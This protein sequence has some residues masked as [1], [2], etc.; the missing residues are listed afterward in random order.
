M[1]KNTA[2]AE[3]LITMNGKAAENALAAL[4]KQQDQ[5]N[6]AVKAG[7]EAQKELDKLRNTSIGEYQKVEGR[8]YVQ[9]MKHLEDIIKKGKENQRTLNRLNKEINVTELATKKY[10]EVLK[11][12]NGSSL[13]ELQAVA[14]QLKFE[15]RQLPPDTQKFIDK[16]KQ[17]KEVNTRINQLTTSFKGLVDQGGFLKRLAGNLSNYFGAIMIGYQSVKRLAQGFM[18]LYKTISNF[19]QANANLASILGATSDQMEKMEKAAIALGSSSRYTAT[20]V[21]ELQT[22]L[23][24]LGFTTDQ[25]V[26]MQKSVLNFAGSVGTDL[27]SAAALAG[28][29]LRSF[30]LRADQTEDALGT[31]AVACN[32]SAL[33]FT[34]L[35]NSFST[36]APVAKTYGLSLKD[37]IALLGTLANA[38]FD[39]SSAATATRNILLNLSDTNGK[40]AKAL[41]GTVNSFGDIMK[42]MI[43]LREQGVDLNDTLELTDKRSVAAFNTFL[44]GAENALELRDAL[45]KVDG[46]LQKIA[47]Q[48]AATV[49][50]AIDG[51]KSAW[52]GL[53]LSFRGSTGTFAKVFRDITDGINA[54]KALIDPQSAVSEAGA[55]L[56]QD[57]LT[58]Q[59]K[60]MLDPEEFGKY[61]EEQLAAYDEK[62]EQAGKKTRRRGW[63]S[64]L[65]TPLL[66]KWADAKGVKTELEGERAVFEAAANDIA[67]TVNLTLG[68]E[69]TQLQNVYNREMKAVED[70]MSLSW[71]EVHQKQAE[72]TEKYYKDRQ[73][74]I[75]KDFENNKAA[76]EAEAK[77]AENAAKKKTQV[78]EKEAKKAALARQQAYNKQK[79]QMEAFMNFQEKSL[80]VAWLS[81]EMGEADYNSLV[82]QMKVKHYEALLELARKYG[83]DDSA[84]RNK[85]LDDHIKA[86]EAEKKRVKEEMEEMMKVYASEHPDQ[87]MSDEDF[88]KLRDN[89][90]RQGYREKLGTIP[91]ET[92]KEFDARIEQYEAFQEKILAKAADI[93]AAITEDSAR[94][95]YETEMK[96][97]EKL[98]KDG[99]LSD[100]EFEKAKMD[101]K[102]GFAAKIAQEVNRYAE[103]ASNFANALKESETAKMEAEYQAQLT[104]AGDNA[105]ERERIETEYEQKKLDM[106]K[107]YADVDMVIN[108]AKAIASGALAAVEAFAAAGGN[109][110]LGGIFAAIIAATTAIEIATIVSQRNAIKNASVSGGGSSSVPKTGERKM[111]GYAEGGYTEDH[112]TLTTVGEKGREW[113]GPAWM[114][115]K[116][117]VMFANLERYRKSG[118]HGRSGSMSRGF[119]DGGFTPGKG[120]GPSA[121]MPEQIDIEAAVEAAIR[122]VMADGAIRAY[123]VRKDIEELDAQTLKFKKLGSR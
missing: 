27:A 111:T 60:K 67:N 101:Q 82:Y 98:H 81:G 7:I 49:E 116:N 112:T 109:P 28:V 103:M 26:A 8:S 12:I 107:K 87:N 68:Q 119:A 25:I 48:R 106:Q 83:Q 29:A 75:K 30:D 94:T 97:I 77:E 88:N 114:V 51:M 113:V 71:N 45:E 20:Q 63:A 42:A 3:V 99:L 50:G 57:N 54:L 105:E 47:D 11:N 73:T 56:I 55:G 80:K 52:E 72:I 58:E 5:C 15:I 100:E 65:F 2:E 115:R 37:T 108:I 4:R 122:R 46:E 10:A 13:A 64:L 78:D 123:V 93:R 118:S 17:L 38:G 32:K 16:T 6:D 86:L 53:V 120:G 66:G 41:G 76:R 61:V 59:Y 85:M 39:A 34:Y 117:P 84:I 96:W 18:E 69:L 95:Q 36:I 35:Q 79:A 33:S 70:D 24:K 22:E 104:A 43:Q 21:T 102:L 23:A 89:Q 91:G 121:S 9:Q 1:A 40:L 44:D 90:R 19:E 14:K 110:V 92:D 62:I 31:M 74:I